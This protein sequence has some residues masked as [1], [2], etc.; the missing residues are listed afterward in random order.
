MVETT[1]SDEPDNEV[2]EERQAE[3]E[4]EPNSQRREGPISR[5]EY[6]ARLRDEQ[7]QRNFANKPYRAR[8]A[9]G[10]RGH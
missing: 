8:G 3:G 4:V 2:E 9:R 10:G 5:R 6:F 7:M 1:E